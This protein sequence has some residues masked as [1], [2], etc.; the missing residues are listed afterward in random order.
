MREA[1]I[2]ISK[3]RYYH[4]LIFPSKQLKFASASLLDQQ[5]DQLV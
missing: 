4:S 5:F 2:A 3:F 1:M